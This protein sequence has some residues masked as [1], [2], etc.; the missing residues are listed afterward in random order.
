MRY[1]LLHILGNHLIRAYARIV[2]KLD[3]VWHA[4]LPPGPKL[5]VANHPSA[6]D[7]FLIH[8]ISTQPM[9]VLISASAFTTPILGDFLRKIEQIP[10]VPQ[11]RGQALDHA[12]RV[13]KNGRSVTIFPEG[14][15]SPQ[16]GGFREPRTGA[17]RLALSTGVPVIPVGIHIKREWSYRIISGVSGKKTTGYWYLHGPYTVTVGEPMYFDGAVDDRQRVAEV[18]NSIMGQIHQLAAESEARWS[19]SGRT[20]LVNDGILWIRAL[21]RRLRTVRAW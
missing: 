21:V 10:V 4:P 8:L 5:F 19:K 6:T 16:E 15:F 1:R 3:M 17:A 14:D 18:S 2:L 7:P 9:S 11:Q 13:I 20:G 12:V